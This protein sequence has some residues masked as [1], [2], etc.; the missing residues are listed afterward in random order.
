MRKIAIEV[1]DLHGDGR[2]Y[3]NS[4][5]RFFSL[6]QLGGMVDN[7]FFAVKA[8]NALNF[9]LRRKDYWKINFR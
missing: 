4:G 3:R 8:F 7:F 2:P 5:K 1:G 9:W 6:E